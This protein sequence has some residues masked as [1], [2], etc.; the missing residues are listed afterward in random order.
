MS[1]NALYLLIIMLAAGAAV[2]GYLYYQDQ[3]S[4]PGIKIDIGESGVSIKSN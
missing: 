1:R 4:K 3:Q 2:L